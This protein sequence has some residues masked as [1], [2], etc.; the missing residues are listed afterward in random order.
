MGGARVSTSTRVRRYERKEQGHDHRTWLGDRQRERI[1]EQLARLEAERA[2][3]R[4]LIAFA[5]AEGLSAASVLKALSLPDDRDA[6]RLPFQAIDWSDLRDATQLRGLKI[7]LLLDA[8]CGLPVEPDIA[9]A[10]ANAARHA[11]PAHPGRPEDGGR[12]AHR[13]PVRR[14]PAPARGCAPA[15]EG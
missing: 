1:L 2:V 15:A 3:V 10:V 8:G 6:T 14:L 13:R 7:G 9:E 12:Q 5:A 11:A 4:T